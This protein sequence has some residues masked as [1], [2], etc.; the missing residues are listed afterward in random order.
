VLACQL[1]SLRAC[2]LASGQ[3][4]TVER[5]EIVSTLQEPAEFKSGTERAAI[6]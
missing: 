3:L 5:K 6:L 2:Q 4:L 1:V